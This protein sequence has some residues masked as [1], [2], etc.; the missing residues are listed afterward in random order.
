[1]R[2]LLF[3]FISIFLSCTSPEN[4]KQQDSDLEATK[5]GEINPP[6]DLYSDCNLEGFESYAG[7]IQEVRETSFNFSDKIATPESSWIASAEYYSCDG[8]TGFF[9]L[10]LDEGREYIHANVPKEIWENFR[11]ASSKGEYYNAA[12]KERYRLVIV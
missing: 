11:N 2:N 4:D 3:V 8:K 1:M 7:A 12:L 6:S 5:I 9:I 10:V